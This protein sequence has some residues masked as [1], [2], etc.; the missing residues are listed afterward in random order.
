MRAE[1]LRANEMNIWVDMPLLLLFVGL[2]LFGLLM[3][4]SASMEFA[5]HRYG[6]ALHFMKRQVFFIALAT[7]IAFA[8]Y[9]GPTDFWFRNSFYI[10][11]ICLVALVVVLI[12]EIG[13]EVNGARR[14]LDFKVITVQPSEGAKL[15]VT[16]FI[17]DYL[18]RR[19][20]EVC[21]SF[22]GFIKP[23][24]V[25]ALPAVLILAQPDYGMA[26]TLFGVAFVMLFIAGGKIWQ[27]LCMLFAGGGALALIAVA[28]PYRWE[29]IKVF[30]DPWSQQ[31]EGGYQ[32]TQSL[33]AV[34][35]GGWFGQG[36]GNGVQKLSYLPEAHTDFIFS[37]IAEELGFIG[38]LLVVAVYFAMMWRCFGVAARAE[39][40]R[41]YAGAFFSYGTGIWITAQAFVNIAVVMGLLPTKGMTLPAVS[42][43]GSSLLAVFVA[44]AIVQRV[45]HDTCC[46]DTVLM[47]RYQM[48]KDHGLR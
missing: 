20:D 2:C 29:R 11:G 16:L 40:Y 23:L 13:R 18:T 42:V 43:G 1:S 17:A 15:A 39:R 27:V 14:W 21:A 37:V 36:L 25:V 47:R 24:V 48:R 28:A 12:P 41:L 38:V 45:H 30:L 35:S 46:E 5:D 6:D 19:R 44:L 10:F 33:I 26:V 31:F 7:V 32:L 34:G 22:K 8:V 3:V 9:L 4:M